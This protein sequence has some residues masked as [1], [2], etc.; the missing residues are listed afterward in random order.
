MERRKASFS[1]QEGTDQ[2]E[3]KSLLDE[4]QNGGAIYKG[5]GA[6]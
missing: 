4:K 1:T 5:E 3:E 6:A 2:K